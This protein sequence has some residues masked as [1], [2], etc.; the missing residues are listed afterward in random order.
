M[1]WSKPQILVLG[2][3]S[4]QLLQATTGAL[5]R[6]DDDDALEI[7]RDSLAVSRPKSARCLWQCR[8]IPAQKLSTDFSKCQSSCRHENP[9]KFGPKGAMR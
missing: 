6:H 9:N 7:Q 4:E 8:P 2:E 3:E 5:S 1:R